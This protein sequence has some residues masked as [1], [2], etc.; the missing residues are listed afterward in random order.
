MTKTWYSSN[1]N[2]AAINSSTGE[3]DIKA[4]GTTNIQ[5]KY[6]GN[7]K[8]NESALSNAVTIS[9]VKR[10][11]NI[12]L[13]GKTVTY[14]NN[15]NTTSLTVSNAYGTLTWGIT[16]ENG[17][18]TDVA[19]INQ[20]TGVITIKKIGTVKVTVYA[21]GNDIYKPSAQA[22]ANLIINA[23]STSQSWSLNAASVTYGSTIDMNTCINGTTKGTK[24]WSVTNRTGSA[25]INASTGV[26]T[27]SKAGT[28]TVKLVAS[29]GNEG[30]YTYSSLEK[31]CTVTINNK[32]AQTLVIKNGNTT[33]TSGEIRLL[34]GS[35][36][37]LTCSGNITTPSW[38]ASSPCAT[39]S[40]EQSTNSTLLPNQITVRGVSA[41]TCTVTINCEENTSYNAATAYVNIVVY[42]K[43]NQTVTIKK[44]SDSK[45]ASG[46]KITVGNKLIL[47]SSGST[48]VKQWSITEGTSYASITYSSN[49]ATIT[50]NA[51][52]RVKVKVIYN[53]NDNYNEGSK[54]I[55][56]YVYDNQNPSV[57]ISNNSTV[58]T[59]DSDS[60]KTKELTITVN[61]SKTTASYTVKNG[62]IA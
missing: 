27:P 1:T 3:I 13:S 21:A 52:G 41:G 44:K 53:L 31:T 36:L 26:L 42:E 45:D 37:T 60:T 6:S 32:Q 9:V 20:T 49:E 8:Y 50:A 56:L 4:S 30:N 15:N 17:L 7:S 51:R 54:E 25:T 11:Q 24:T 28:V 58:Y 38:A 34:K 62:N 59:S 16:T 19:T 29:G 18:A 40:N 48:S 47:V 43:T 55:Y 22:S 35:T 14:G 23:A 33:V 12:S 57:T 10:N 5:V 2:V 39:L 61:N 46:S